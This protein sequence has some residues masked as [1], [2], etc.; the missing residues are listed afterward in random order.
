LDAINRKKIIF[1]ERFGLGTWLA[2]GG[3]NLFIYDA[4]IKGL[5]VSYFPSFIVQHPFE[6]TIKS[7]PKYAQRR[8]RVTG[9]FDA[10]INGYFA[11][12]KA[13]AATFK[14]LPDLLINKKPPHVYLFER[15]SGVFYILKS[16]F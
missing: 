6:S 12:L 3:E 1:D 13:F 7:F 2:G 8:V 9:A 5:K 11:I 16:Q 15:L 10:R 4:I 14:F